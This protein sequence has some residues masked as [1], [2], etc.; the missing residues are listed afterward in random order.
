M[1]VG[2]TRRKLRKWQRYYRRNYLNGGYTKYWTL[3]RLDD[4]V[5]VWRWAW[6]PGVNH[7][8]RAEMY[9]HWPPGSL[10]NRGSE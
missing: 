9:L 8:Q 3:R 10:P 7:W 2:A 4:R 6:W 5:A 1:R